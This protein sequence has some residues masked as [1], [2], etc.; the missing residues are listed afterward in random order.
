VES[1]KRER[2]MD[3]KYIV[4]VVALSLAIAVMAVVQGRKGG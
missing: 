3:R 4:G 2:D 1:W